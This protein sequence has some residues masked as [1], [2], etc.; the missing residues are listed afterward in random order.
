MQHLALR[1][2]KGTHGTPPDERPLVSVG[3]VPDTFSPVMPSLVDE[4]EIWVLVH[5]YDYTLYVYQVT[6]ENTTYQQICLLVP[7]GIRLSA[8]NNPYGLLLELWG[9]LESQGNQR[10]LFEERLA[11]SIIGKQVSD[12]RLPVMDG[13]QPASFCADSRMQVKALLMFSQYPQLA[14]VSRLEIGLHCT[15]TISLPIKA[16]VKKVVQPESV[17]QP[18]PEKPQAEPSANEKTKNEQAGKKQNVGKKVALYAFLLVAAV[19]VIGFV[20]N[21]IEKDSSDTKGFTLSTDTVVAEEKTLIAEEKPDNPIEEIV[22]TD[23]EKTN[24]PEATPSNQQSERE[25]EREKVEKERKEWARREILSLVNRNDLSGCRDHR[26]WL[27]CLTNDERNAIETTL[28]YLNGF[29]EK[30]SL[31]VGDTIKRL[32][33]N[34]F[35]FKSFDEIINVRK[36]IIDIKYEDRKEQIKKKNK[37][38]Y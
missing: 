28:Y 25:N 10:A 32:I 38:S 1:I 15:S 14:R 30:L 35:P 18:K 22:P 21:M 27:R 37:K 4:P 19:A 17:H 7:V 33:D 16:N 31:T 8:D 20:F 5:L 36:K 34:N 6:Q 24:S 29:N 2:Y 11:L 12:M 3:T 9:I 13:Q 26:G 23:I